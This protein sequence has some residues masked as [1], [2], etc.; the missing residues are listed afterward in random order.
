MGGVVGLQNVWKTIHNCN[1][2]AL[3]YLKNKREFEQARARFQAT[4]TKHTINFPNGARVRLARQGGQLSIG[5]TGPIGRKCAARLE[6]VLLPYRRVAAA[7]LERMDTALITWDALPDINED[8]YR[9]GIPPSAVIVSHSQYD[10]T[11]EFCELLSKVGVLRM[12]FL[13]EQAAVAQ[14]WVDSFVAKTSPLRA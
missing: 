9:A 8:L 13:P 4:A 3:N 7:S 2:T 6:A 11:M 12:A 14:R 5:Y 1:M 10:R